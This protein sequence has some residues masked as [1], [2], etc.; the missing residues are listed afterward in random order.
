[1]LNE[2]LEVISYLCDP[3]ITTASPQLMFGEVKKGVK[4]M[5]LSDILVLVGAHYVYDFSEEK[6]VDKKT[7]DKIINILRIWCGFENDVDKE[8]LTQIKEENKEWFETY[9]HADG[10]FRK[11]FETRFDS[12]LWSKYGTKYKLEK[13]QRKIYFSND[14]SY[15]DI[16]AQIMARGE[17]K[18]YYLAVKKE[19]P[20]VLA[21]EVKNEKDKSPNVTRQ[22]NIIKFIASHKLLQV[23][24]PNQN[25][26][27]L[28]PSRILNWL[29]IKSDKEN[30]WCTE[31]KWQGQPLFIKD[32]YRDFKKFT[33]NPEFLEL[34]DVKLIKC[35]EEVDTNEYI[36]YKDGGS[37][38][39][40]LLIEL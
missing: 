17:L 28:Q 24:Q 8:L 16:L 22:K 7:K 38:K 1:M 2:K 37:G 25:S 14:F 18:E 32:S 3:K 29:G 21:Q 33:V 31:F 9:P 4:I 40:K 26:V 5:G 10:W 13:M 12:E 34:L 20:T 30:R 6:K 11:F 19:Y 15:Y 35:I 23:F 39:D 36:I 27:V